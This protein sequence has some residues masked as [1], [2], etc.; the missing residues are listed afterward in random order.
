METIIGINIETK[1]AR[2]QELLVIERDYS[3]FWAYNGFLKSH[4]KKIISKYTDCNWYIG[5]SVA[6]LKNEMVRNVIIFRIYNTK[7]F[8][9]KALRQ[10]LNK[11]IQPKFK[12]LFK[13]KYQSSKQSH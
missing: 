1:T 11:Y 13:I 6:F 9:K 3:S 7:G 5:A 10:E 8:N 4:C 12:R 2:E